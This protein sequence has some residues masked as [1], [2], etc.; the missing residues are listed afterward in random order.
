MAAEAGGADIARVAAPVRGLPGHR[1]GSR[2]RMSSLAV[3][4]PDGWDAG[5]VVE[6]TAGESGTGADGRMTPRGRATVRARLDPGWHLAELDGDLPG[7]GVAARLTGLPVNRG[8]RKALAAAA[9]DGLP[10]DSLAA[11]L[12]DDL[13]TVQLVSGYA[14]LLEGAPAFPARKKP[15]EPAAGEGR[16][17][18]ALNICRGWAPGGT[19]HRLVLSG[20]PPVTDIP[21]APA[22]DDLLAGPEDFLGEPPLRP[23]SMRRRRILEVGPADGQAEIWEYFR[24]S[25]LDGAGRERSLHEYLVTAVV[26]TADLTVSAISVEPRALPFPECPL[27]SSGAQALV[28]TPLPG[29]DRA[30]RTRLAGLAGCTHLNDVLRF[31]RFAQPLI[32]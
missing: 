31:L 23:H 22:F 30:V 7:P 28:G 16:T 4:A 17:G 1:P 25:H 24:D 9:A 6:A 20:E 14:R 2:R 19:A 8:F 32:G 27:A 10:P 29:I 18:P 13:P 3:S 26:D 12:L 5:T 15:E 21:A 11:A